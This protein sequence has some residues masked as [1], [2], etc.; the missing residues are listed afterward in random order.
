MAPTARAISALLALV[1]LLAAACG[2]EPERASAA[3]VKEFRS[4]IDGLCQT[5]TSLR[6]ENVP[7]AIDIFTDRTH[8][9]LHELVD[10]LQ[11]EN[12]ALAA[13]LLEAKQAMETALKDPSFY[14][15]KEVARRFGELH[16]TLLR[17]AEVMGLPQVGCSA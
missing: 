15:R 5:A 10:A 1:A 2:G 14:G 8:A 3:E 13:R 17:V 12:R 11:K 16:N 9:Y 4:A 7:E 6:Q